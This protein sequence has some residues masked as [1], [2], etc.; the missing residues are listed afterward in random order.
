VLAE[1]RVRL[2]ATL[3]PGRGLRV[4]AEFRDAD[5]AGSVLEARADRFDLLDGT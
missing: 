5:P 2:G 3:A 4:Q 1:Q